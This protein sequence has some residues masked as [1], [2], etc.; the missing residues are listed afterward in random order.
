M[1]ADTEKKAAGICVKAEKLRKKAEE[2]ARE[3]NSGSLI[4]K[5]K[6]AGQ[7]HAAEL[8]LGM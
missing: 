1:C 3:A 2:D 6:E 8:T 5:Q 7:S 4:K